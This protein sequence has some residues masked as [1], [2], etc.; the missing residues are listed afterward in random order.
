M[1][2]SHKPLQ[3]EGEEI[4]ECIEV[5]IETDIL[6]AQFDTIFDVW[7]FSILCCQLGERLG[8][9][10]RHLHLNWYQ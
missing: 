10:V 3:E 1:P 5:T 9:I 7:I 2:S 8:R 6:I 4:R